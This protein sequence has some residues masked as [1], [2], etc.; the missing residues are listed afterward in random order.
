M[1]PELFRDEL[2]AC[3]EGSK[4]IHEIADSYGKEK[5]FL[6]MEYMNGQYSGGWNTLWYSDK[7]IAYFLVVRDSMNWT[8]LIKHDL[9][10][11]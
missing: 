5:A 6:R 10:N 3:Q 8:V 9:R 2:D 1:K 4:F 11:L 7:L